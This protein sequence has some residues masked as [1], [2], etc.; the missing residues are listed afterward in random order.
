MC[1]WS[2]ATGLS[3][4]NSC[5]PVASPSTTTTYSLTVSGASGCTSMNSAQVTVTVDAIC[6]GPSKFYTL[7]PCRVVD[8]RSATGPYGGPSLAVGGERTFSFAEQCGIPSGARSLV[9]NVT[10]T[11]PTQPG[12]LTLRPAGSP[13]PVASNL[14]FSAGQT[15]AEIATVTLNDAGELTVFYGGPAG[16]KVHVVI[17]VSG[18]Y[19]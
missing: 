14:N 8:T 17:D 12:F 4:P 2:P 19:Q 10:A 5:N 9:L 18:Y 11:E 3:D 16:G 6:R 13:L 15:R 1:S 7:A